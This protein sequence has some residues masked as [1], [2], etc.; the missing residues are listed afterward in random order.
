MAD[1]DV[2]ILLS[3]ILFK[4]RRYLTD[5]SSWHFCSWSQVHQHILS[6]DSSTFVDLFSSDMCNIEDRSF[7][8]EG[9]NDEKPIQLQGDTVDEFRDLLWCLYAL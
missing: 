5:E 8:Q 1:G 2:T 6:R 4:V 3:N 7:Q 9:C